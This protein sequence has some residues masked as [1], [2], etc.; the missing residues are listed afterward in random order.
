MKIDIADPHE[1]YRW[2]E[3]AHGSRERQEGVF[4]V[5]F[6]ADSA[7][8]HAIRAEIARIQKLKLDLIQPQMD[9][10]QK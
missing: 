8:V 2:L 9:L 3:I 1:L 7:A 10:R 4:K 6:G 5:Q